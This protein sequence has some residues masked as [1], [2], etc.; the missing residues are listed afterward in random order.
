MII[1]SHTHFNS[2]ASTGISRLSEAAPIGETRIGRH[3]RK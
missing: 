2:L 1:G 3:G